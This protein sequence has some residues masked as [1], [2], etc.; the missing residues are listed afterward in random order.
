MWNRHKLGECQSSQE[1]VVRSLKIGDLKLYGLHVK[2]FPSP[3][4]HGKSDLAI[5]GCCCTMGYVMERT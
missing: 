2:I 5:G 3:E 1:S 4:G